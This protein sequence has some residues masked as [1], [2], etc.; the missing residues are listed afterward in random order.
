MDK[1]IALYNAL[2]A[3][4]AAEMTEAHATLTVYFETPVGI[5]E[6]PQIVGEMAKQLENLANAE[7]CLNSLEKNFKSH[8]IGT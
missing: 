3:R 5:G 6:H 8:I 7:D 4:Y 1:K 2:Q